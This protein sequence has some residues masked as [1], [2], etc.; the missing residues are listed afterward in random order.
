MP[1]HSERKG[2]ELPPDVT[3]I[4]VIGNDFADKQTDLAAIDHV[5]NL[6]ASACVLWYC[7]LASRIQK[8]NVCIMASLEARKM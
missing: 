3:P 4:D 5:I 1:S 8:R 2:T 7:S 6:N